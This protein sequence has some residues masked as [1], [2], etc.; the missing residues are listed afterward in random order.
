MMHYASNIRLVQPFLLRDKF[1]SRVQS[2]HARAHSIFATSLKHLRRLL[3]LHE[4]CHGWT[5]AIAYVLHP[6]MVTG[7]G[8]LDEIISANL[9]HMALEMSEPYLG[10]LTCLRALSA[11]SNFIYYAQPLFRLLTQAC[12]AA[13]MKLPSEVLRAEKQYQSEEWTRSAKGL[14]SSRYVADM[15]SAVKEMESR[16]LDTV[17]AQWDALTISEK[18]QS[19]VEH[20]TP[21]SENDAK[22]YMV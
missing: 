16:R 14:V 9:S 21:T 15:S 7:F 8:S 17:I 2:Y 19:E 1:L 5:N 6:I 13:D 3:T 11:I 18:S 22:R 20:E 12:Q 10:L 4:V